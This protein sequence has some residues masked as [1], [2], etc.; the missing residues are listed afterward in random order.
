MSYDGFW[1][2]DANSDDEYDALTE[3]EQQLYDIE[4]QI[5]VLEKQVNNI[6]NGYTIIW[7]KTIVP[8]MNISCGS[9][10]LDKLTTNDQ[11]KFIKYMLKNNSVYNEVL[12]CLTSLK[13]KQQDISNKLLGRKKTTK[14][15]KKSVPKM[16]I[17][18][19]KH[20]IKTIENVKNI[21]IKQ[22][23]KNVWNSSSKKL[24]E[25]W[26]Q[27]STTSGSRIVIT[28]NDCTTN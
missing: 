24:Q 18:G 13:N 17:I 23:N 1:P 16:I 9:G 22:V 26:K 21:A 11:N 19:K 25:T 20:K 5:D 28:N 6:E 2:E 15:Y 8:Y 3:E 27:N 12:I 4:E 14:K 10:I 7:N